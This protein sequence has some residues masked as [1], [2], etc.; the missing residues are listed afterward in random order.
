MR[1]QYILKIAA[2]MILTSGMLLVLGVVAAWNIQRQQIV[3]SDL[4]QK[5]VHGMIATQDLCNDIREIRHELHQYRNDGSMHH[6]EGIDRRCQGAAEHLTVAKGLIRAPHEKDAVLSID[7][8]W[9]QFLKQYSDTTPKLNE[10]SPDD[11]TD[12][13][14]LTDPLLTDIT[15]VLAPAKEYLALDRML[16]DTTNESSRQA[17]EVVRQTLLWMAIC[18][19]LAG[20]VGGVMIA[21]SIGQ[22][23]VQ[24]EVSVR[25]AADRLQGI[26]GPVTILQPNGLRHL[27]AGLRQVENHIATVVERLRQ[28]ELDVLRSDQLAAVGQLAAGVAHELRN[29]LMPMKM[30]VQAAVERDDGIGLCGRQLL[31]V[32]EEIERME[33][34]IQE[35]LDFA[36][37]PSLE[38]TRF[39][40]RVAIEQTVELISQQVDR[41]HIRIIDDIPEE[42]LPIDADA[43]QIRQV[44]LNLF[45]NAIEALAAGGRIEVCVTRSCPGEVEG[46][47]LPTLSNEWICIAISDNGPGLSADVIERVFEPFVSTKE[48]GTGLGLSICRRIVEVHGG[49]IRAANRPEGG[50]KFSIYLPLADTDLD[51]PVA[52]LEGMGLLTG[53]A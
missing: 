6:L 49:I 7:Q 37:P 39:D 36:R 17:T 33:R 18:G 8:G 19:G 29:P 9:Q 42:E 16:L 24:L 47:P 44:L 28:R 53:F 4:I 50:A 40:L 12:R 25:G 15:Q 30:L 2:P 52:E 32:E 46:R 48:T 22:S 26:V 1:N 43:S 31:V 14:A 20:V 41:Q 21:R 51:K 3:S 13:L 38:I 34:S 27:E 23:V 35:F 45:L 5:E 11:R 10:L